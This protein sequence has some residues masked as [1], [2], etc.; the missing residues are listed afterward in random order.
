MEHLPPPTMT[1][2]WQ[3]GGPPDSVL[4]SALGGPQHLMGM[5]GTLPTVFFLHVINSDHVGSSGVKTC[6]F[7]VNG[8]PQDTVF[9]VAPPS[10]LKYFG[11]PFS[12]SFQIEQLENKQM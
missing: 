2:H 5:E 1:Q 3:P 8:W 10:L 11:V 12:Y 9:H 7:Q 6:E 4:D